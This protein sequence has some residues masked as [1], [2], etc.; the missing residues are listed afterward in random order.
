MKYCGKIAAHSLKSLSVIL[1]SF[2][3]SAPLTECTPRTLL[4]VFILPPEAVIHPLIKPSLTTY[5]RDTNRMMERITF[6]I[7]NI[8]NPF[9][10]ARSEERRVGKECKYK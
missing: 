7:V 4:P 8:K 3:S 1:I 10:P 9:K 5:V 2:L 6:N